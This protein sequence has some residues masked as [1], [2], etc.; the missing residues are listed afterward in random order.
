MSE[1]IGKTVSKVLIQE[2]L[3]RGGMA[4]V[5]LGHHT[6][7][8]RPVAVKI[9]HSFLSEDE[10]AIRRFRS[11]AQAV[12]NL[13]HANIVQVYDFDL[14]DHQPY[15]VM[16]L[17][18]G[19]PLDEY[20]AGLKKEGRQIPPETVVRLTFAL[21]S[22]LDYAHER[23]IVHRDI[24]PSNVILHYENGDIAQL[25][26]LPLDVDVV[27]CDF[28]VARLLHESRVS[29]SGSISGTPA[30]FSPEQ[31]RGEDVDARSD[32]YSLGVVIYE[33]LSGRLPFDVAEDSPF[34]YLLKH[35]SEPPIPLTN[36]SIEVWAVLERVLS[37]KKED[38]H[39]NASHLA[40]DLMQ[41]VFG[42]ALPKDTG[43]T[44]PP[45]DGLLET[46][47]ALQEQVEN[48]ELTLPARDYTA[49]A[50]LMHLGDMTRLALNEA[51]ELAESV[52]PA[53]SSGHPF[54]GRE[55][56]ILGLM[57]QGM[58]NKEMAYRLGISERTVEFHVNSVFNK[59]GSN[60]RMEAVTISLRNNWIHLD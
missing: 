10:D 28:G 51:Q 46:L 52:R 6:T 31:A 36:T 43:E 18:K 40:L 33:M 54:S 1:W 21:A 50:I 24:K 23:G 13:R 38:R 9:L 60:S 39:K 2:R 49:R 29:V 19:V 26:V 25:D 11:E 17:I 42:V 55:Y 7:L 12:A 35:I 3:G 37:K 4:E 58:T 53:F 57:V 41:A 32:I 47:K 44:R 16:G 27:L 14:V 59:T 30:Y 45:L 56:E 34:A 22:A 8:D 5:Y 15:I 48:Y 20:L